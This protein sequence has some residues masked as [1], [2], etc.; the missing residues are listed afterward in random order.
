MNQPLHQ[1]HELG[2]SIWYDNI[3][4]AMLDSGRL[5]EY[6]E[7]YAVTG[8]T[9]NP[10]I[11]ERAIA[12]SSD[13]DTALRAAVERGVRDPEA[14]FWELAIEDIRDAADVL[15]PVY[16][17]S[18]GED[19]F[20]SLEL[21]PRLSRDTRGSVEFGQELFAR[22]GRPNAM[23]KV[24]G[25]AEGVE[26]IEELIHRGVNVNVTLLFSLLQW[27]A[28]ADAYL[29]GLDRRA[30]EGLDLRVASVA[31]YFIS[32]IDAKANP[33]L[34]EPLQNRLGV[35]SAQ[36][37]FTA[38]RRMLETEGW[39]R[40][41]SLDAQPQRLLWASTSTKDPA[42]PETFYVR[43]L[44]APGTVNTMPESTLLAFARAGEL[45][46]AMSAESA[47]TAGAVEA[48]LGHGVELDALGEE[49]QAEG[50]AAFAD[51]FDRLL[52]CIATKVRALGSAARPGVR[53]LDPIADEVAAVLADLSARDAV[54]RLWT[55]DHTLWQDEPNEVG[56]R[57]GWLLQP[58]AM[59]DEVERLRDFT[60]GARADGLTHALVVGM[61]GSSLFP[62]VIART[63]D[64][65]REALELHV[66]DSDDPVAIRRVEQ[67]LPLERTLVIASSKSGTTAE[68]RSLLE[69]FWHRHPVAAHFAVISDPGTP[70]AE[71][72][73]ERG[74]RAVFEARA[75]IGGRY[76]ALSHFGLVPAALAG[77]DVAELLHRAGRMAAACADCVPAAD[78]PG[79]QL[80][81]TLAGAARAGRD[82]LTLVIDERYASFGLWIEQLIA[83]S[84]GKRGIGI[85]PVVGE[86]LGPPTVYGDDRIFVGIGVDSA[87]IDALA[88]AGHP[89]VTLPLDEPADLGAEV[90]RWEI[91]TALAGAAL[92]INPFD[93]P[94]VEAAK[95]AAR[96][97]LEAG[98]EPVGATS[99]HELLE[100]LGAGDYLAIQAYTDPDGP[101][102]EELERIRRG[103]RDRYRVATTLGVGPRYLHSTGQLHKGGPAS[104]VFLQIVPEL[105]DDLAIPGERFGFATLE[106]AQAAGDLA[107]L[108]G[109]G[110]RAGRVELDELRTVLGGPHTEHAAALAGG[111][112]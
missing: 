60:R 19:G 5:R 33:R 17:A 65:A 47:E 35:A 38:Y 8:V 40:L 21:P 100:Q 85:V 45:D 89:V 26:A 32:R 101:L 2:Q 91:G 98:V 13:Y 44:A 84:T 41:A 37:A 22:V 28:V 56:D 70:L 79:L 92:G 59:E 72:G 1:L 111:V 77:T 112:S 50:D 42:L 43:V 31:S 57:L 86:A 36:L 52:G 7:E 9:S 54:R 63:V 48:A 55:R 23:I 14:L 78:N 51:A 62:L 104:G 88:E 96:R 90:L 25:T 3:R 64:G 93:Q 105:G 27:S 4:R 108:R 49:L 39:Q 30:A 76:A 46:G 69:Y 11:F 107:A 87:R 10:S 94:D 24:P 61:G 58:E 73:R 18:D 29:R 110:R 95:D 20:V 67:A 103:L 99:A 75:D 68:T 53:R 34:P 16:E 106:R 82:K 74:F 12:G 6:V 80:A 71:L 97:S 15:R 81:A 109:R 102:V 66:L 83:E